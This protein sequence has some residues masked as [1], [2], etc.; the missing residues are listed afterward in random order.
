MIGKKCQQRLPPSLRVVPIGPV[1]I[2]K[3]D[4]LS[5]DVF[6]L[7]VAVEVI[8]KAGHSVVKVV[9]LH[10]IFIVHDKFHELQA[11]TL[12]HSQHDIIVKKLAWKEIIDM[13]V[14]VPTYANNTVGYC[15][16]LSKVRHYL[17]P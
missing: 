16:L 3:L 12:V 8:H 4:G 13:V 14:N 17:A 15:W 2:H 9:S 5:E 6:T 1:G 10:T 7:W 11:L